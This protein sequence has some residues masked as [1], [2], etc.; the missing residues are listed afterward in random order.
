MKVEIITYHNCLFEKMRKN[1][2]KMVDFTLSLNLTNND[3]K[4]N[5]KLEGGMGGSFFYVSYDNLLIIKS[6]DDGQFSVLKEKI[7]QMFE[8]FKEN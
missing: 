3:M 6:L 1:D 4:N 5:I 8:F 7:P 2:Q